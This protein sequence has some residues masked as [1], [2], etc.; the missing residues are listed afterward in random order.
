MSKKPDNIKIP[1][2]LFMDLCRYHV[3]GISDSEIE[4]RIQAGL[5]DKMVAAAAREAYIPRKG[6]KP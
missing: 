4:Q 3:F 2:G 5:R 6:Q 1:Y